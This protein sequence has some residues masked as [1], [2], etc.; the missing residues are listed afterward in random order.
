MTWFLS[1]LGGVLAHELDIERFQLDNGLTLLTLEE[2]ALPV[3]S[4]Y[5]F[6]RAGSR[7]ERP[8]ITGIS[9]LFEHMMFNGS[10]K[11]PPHAFD[12]ILEENGGAS[13]GYTT[14][15]F[16]AYLEDFPK[17]A[18][19]LILDMEADRMANLTITPENLEQE[20]GIVKEE[21]RLRTD[22]SV[23]G[24]MYEELNA[25]A[26]K[27][28]PYRWP[29]V[30]WMADLD[31]ITLADTEAY[32][33]TYYA[34][35]NAVLVLVGDFDTKAA[36]ERVVEKFGAIPAQAPPPPV[37]NAEEPQRGEKRIFFHKKAQLPAF[38]VGYHLPSGKDP[39]FPAL[40]LLGMILSHGESSRV[41]RKLIYETE[42]AVEASIEVRPQKDPGLLVGYVQL[43]PGRSVEE[44][45]K[46]LYDVI[47]EVRK[48][49]VTER[50][51][52]KAKNQVKAA[53]IRALKTNSG[54]AEMIGFFEM[55][56][57]DYREIFKTMA[58]YDAVTLADIRRVAERWLTPLARTVLILVPEDPPT[59]SGEQR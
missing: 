16:T 32:F 50:E 25:A 21:R 51:L 58:R 56:Y 44:G 2:H 22:N 35:N 34:P 38:M 48:G 59:L 43:K 41:Y 27:A 3:V 45:E 1:V 5:V 54:K 10:R 13:N 15:D 37:V 49:G 57:D 33:R 9:H 39:D 30:G 40:E 46:A 52:A 11:Y 12:Q 14:E 17:G 31:A 18:L 29:V 47:E 20:R 19:D 53:F 4:L 23:V 8:G 55:I 7:N 42:I 36:R 6:Y 28:H 24:K 26:Y